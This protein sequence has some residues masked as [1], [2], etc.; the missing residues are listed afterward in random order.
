MH[1]EQGVRGDEA[2]QIQGPDALYTVATDHLLAE[3][4]D[5]SLL[6]VTC[7]SDRLYPLP[8]QYRTS[9]R[10][11]AIGRSDD[12]L[13]A[14]AVRVGPSP[15]YSA[16]LDVFSRAPF[17]CRRPQRP[18]PCPLLCRTGCEANRCGARV[19]RAAAQ[20]FDLTLAR[21]V[22]NMPP[23]EQKSPDITPGA[24]GFTDRIRTSKRP[25][26]GD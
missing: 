4:F 21:K 10:L 1:D 6:N 15:L 25:T 18:P 13:P 8:M 7:P 9:I 5:R 20:S 26:Y 23:F 12:R 14:D 17:S 3:L 16:E 19:Y 11:S 22:L 2:I 24:L